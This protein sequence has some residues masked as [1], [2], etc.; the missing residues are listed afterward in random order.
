[1]TGSAELR[2]SNMIGSAKLRSSDMIG[3][4]ELRSYRS[5]SLAMNAGALLAVLYVRA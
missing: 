2:S 5:R 1:M 3:S 4:A